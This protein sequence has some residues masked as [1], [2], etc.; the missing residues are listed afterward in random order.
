MV[1]GEDWVAMDTALTSFNLAD[2]GCE[3]EGNIFYRQCYEEKL[4]SMDRDGDGTI[5]VAEA[6]SVAEERNCFNLTRKDIK[7]GLTLVTQWFPEDSSVMMANEALLV[8]LTFRNAIPSEDTPL[9]EDPLE[10]VPLPRSLQRLPA[11]QPSG[12]LTA[13]ITQECADSRI[14]IFLT[15]LELFFQILGFD[16]VAGPNL[17]QNLADAIFTGSGEFAMA[18]R[19]I[20]T[21]MDSMPTAMDIATG[22]WGLFM[23][24]YE[25]GFVLEG[26]RYV[27]SQMGWWRRA[28]TLIRIASTIILWI[29][30]SGAVQILQIALMIV[31][32]DDL[33]IAFREEREDCD[34]TSNSAA[35]AR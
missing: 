12:N 14:G 15:A 9:P 30:S 17:N 23:A 29:V 31:T 13:M 28:I 25:E 34:E 21:Y 5:A 3:R 10:G 27:V 8:D 24:M 35:V 6:V 4:G 20:F 32:I 2:L 16:F 18:V 22:A 33:R 19:E 11:R 26:I 7:A 1:V